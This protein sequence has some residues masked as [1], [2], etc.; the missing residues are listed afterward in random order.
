MRRQLDTNLEG[1]VEPEHELL[2]GAAA[3][4]DDRTVPVDCA[5][6]TPPKRVAQQPPHPHKSATQN[7][8]FLWRMPS[9]ER[10]TAGGPGTDS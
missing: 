5:G 8:M 6:Q 4:L 10:L 7:V 1:V 2:G 3:R 9:P